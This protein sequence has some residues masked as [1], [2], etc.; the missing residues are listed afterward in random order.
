MQITKKEKGNKI[1]L[2]RH[3]LP[4]V[5]A[6]MFIHVGITGHAISPPSIPSIF[7]IPPPMPAIFCW[8]F[9]SWNA[10]ALRSASSLAEP[11]LDFNHL[12]KLF[13]MGVHGQVGLDLCHGD[14]LTVT[15]GGQHLIERETSSNILSITRSSSSSRNFRH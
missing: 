8:R 13:L 5:A 10:L 4:A 14:I 12:V 3:Y 1:K 7:D 9:S 6:H 11:I 2:L 15:T